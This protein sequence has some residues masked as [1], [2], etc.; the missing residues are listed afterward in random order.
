MRAASLRRASALAFAVIS[1]VSFAYAE[2]P[3]IRP[4]SLP[5]S[6]GSS[7]LPE[8]TALDQHDVSARLRGALANLLGEPSPLAGASMPVHARVATGSGIDLRPHSGTPR[9]LSFAALGIVPRV[10][11]ALAGDERD[12]AVA[13]AALEEAAPYLGIE[14]PSRELRFTEMVRDELGQRHLRFVQEF[15]GIPV[16][17]AELIVHID[18]AGRALSM[19]G[20]FVRTPRRLSTRPTVSGE[21]VRALAAASGSP[22]GLHVTEPE[23]VVWAPEGR[24]PRLAWKLETFGGMHE[25]W[26]LFVDAHSGREIEKF[27]LIHTRNVSGSGIDLLGLRRTLSVWN[28]TSGG[29]FLVDSSKNMFDSTSAPPHPGTTRGAISVFHADNKPIFD[30]DGSLYYSTSTDPHSWND[31]HAVSAA[32]ALGQTYDYFLDRHGRKSFD[33]KGKGMRAIVR[34]DRNYMNAFWTSELE[35]M[36]FGDADLFAG[37]VDVVAHEMTHAVTS[38][39]ARLVYKNQSGAINE[40]MSDVFGE[41]VEARANGSNDW[42]IGTALT[43]DNRRSM[44]Q[45]ELYGQPSRMSAF[46]HTTQDN[47]GVHINSGII[48]KAFYNLAAGL[49]GAIG[50]HDAERIFYRALTTRLSANSDFLDMRLAA[51]QS[52]KEL[53]GASS[54]QAMKTAAAFDSVEIFEAAPPSPKPSTP[55]VA[56]ADSTIFL[57]VQGGNRFVGRRETAAGDPALGVPIAFTTAAASRPSV[58]G[59]GTKAFFVSSLHDACLVTTA[60]PG[61]EQCLG[62]P[63]RISSVAMSR[64][65]R[66]YAFV[67]LEG[68]EP[69]DRIAVIDGVT[70]ATVE[71]SLLSAPFDGDAFGSIVYADSM[72]FSADSQ[73]VVYDAFNITWYPG[74]SAF[75]S[76]TI[77]ALDLA[78][79]V[80]FP[81]VDPIEGLDIT[82]PKLGNTRDEHLTFDAQTDDESFVFTMNLETGAYSY[83]SSDQIYLGIPSFRG[84]DR[85]ILFTHEDSAAPGGFSIGSWALAADYVSFTGQASQWMADAYFGVTYRRG[86]YL[87]PATQPGKLQ[88]SSPAWTADEG[89]I[90]TVSVSR[91]GGV[92]GAVSVLYRTENG[93]AIAGLDY[94]PVTGMLT[95][96]EGDSQPKTF[97]VQLL[98]DGVAEPVETLSVVIEGAGG[99]ASLGTPTRATISIRDSQA[100]PPAPRRRTVRRP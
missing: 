91:T 14:A 55:P 82:W 90:V 75:G 95:W 28:P 16:W 40:A 5:P 35:Y 11:A 39:S 92:K 32:W 54:N 73:W 20:A 100:P 76:W 49:P 72:D 60:T 46:V 43:P 61:S 41:M 25:R 6:F 93:S 22:R 2:A 71:Y 79:G 80:S 15:R 26:Q 7:T 33:G 70:G 98:A 10:A 94:M 53:F 83:F 65:Q 84:D 34:Y 45:P 51:I 57:Y 24:V 96:V 23:L 66:K 67:F 99:G 19:N 86:A 21:S 37:S 85:A 31:R 64:D 1:V 52:A 42:I 13:R 48:N 9:E 8:L 77:Y 36:V 78:S 87:G 69:S 56:A 68:G 17:P 29:Y 89:T 74:G 88:L 59:D 63:G 47:G 27:S 81:I 50:I 30:T 18:E 58:S 38:S 3:S 4:R 44:K 97:K 62:F 12:L